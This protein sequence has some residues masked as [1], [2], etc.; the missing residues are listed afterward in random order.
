MMHVFDSPTASVI[1]PSDAQ[2]FP[3][4]DAEYP[5]APVPVTVCDPGETVTPTPFETAIPSMKSGKAP[6]PS[7]P[8]LLFMT[9]AITVSV[10]VVGTS[11]FVMVHVFVSPSAIVLEQSA[12][13]VVRYPAGP[14]SET[15]YGPASAVISVPVSA[16]GNE[17]ADGL[18]AV[19]F[20]VKSPAL[21]MPP[22]SFTT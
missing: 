6:G 13:Y 20:T 21:D 19:R 10:A 18:T 14:V 9:F 5:P 8:L 22:L 4:G 7:E 1:V 15:L 3:H 12:E 11:L 17:L 2:W 16:P